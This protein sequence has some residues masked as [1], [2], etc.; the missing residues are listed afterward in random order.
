[1]S[2]T[3]V[4][5]AHRPLRSGFTD[6]NAGFVR[7]GLAVARPTS[8]PTRIRI[9]ALLVASMLGSHGQRAHAAGGIFASSFE[10][11]AGSGVQNI[12]LETSPDQLPGRAYIP[13]SPNGAA[14]ILMHGCTGMWQ[15]QTPGTEAQTAIEK[16]GIQLARNGYFALAIDGYT[17][18]MP[19]GADPDA[20]QSQ[21]TGSRYEGAVAPYTTRAAD[22]DEGIEWLRYHFG[23]NV[24][25]VGV[26]G[27]S[28]GAEATLVR[29]AETSRDADISLY[30][31]AADEARALD[32]SVVFYPGCGTALGFVSGARV[33]SSFWRPHHDLRFNV[34][35]L[36]PLEAECMTRATIAQTNFDAVD[37]T[38]H[39]VVLTPYPDA[40]H[41]FDT[42]TA[43]WPV[44]RCAP[45]D[46]PSNECA[47]RAAD[48]D[49]YDFFAARLGY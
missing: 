12:V 48:L 42:F 49:S 8:R 34:A 35:D 7:S 4:P 31:T 36:D 15:H 18:R 22:I 44:D 2:F 20:W 32:A 1:M 41:S 25:R 43:D 13:E 23:S 14:V 16:W 45:E 39:E 29:S 37:G 6:V 21:C 19:S 28:Q 27:W 9:A 30:R 46:P 17:S 40:E 47:A 26:L 10:P 5:I 24:K 3:N 33:D 38:A 11:L